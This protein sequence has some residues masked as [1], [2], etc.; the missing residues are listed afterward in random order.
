M[1][2]IVRKLFRIILCHLGLSIQFPK[3]QLLKEAFKIGNYQR[4]TILTSLWNGTG[5]AEVE[6]TPE[7]SAGGYQ[8][9][10][11]FGLDS[12]GFR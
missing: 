8:Q 2:I 5:S 3:T 4:A 11:S 6:D 9:L 12:T 10:Y 7:D 1:N